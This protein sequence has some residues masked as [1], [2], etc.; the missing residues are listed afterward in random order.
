LALTH[1]CKHPR[2]GLRRRA[3]VGSA[4]ILALTHVCKHPRLGLRRRAPVGSADILAL[5]HVCKH[6]RLGL[7]R[8][9]MKTVPAILSA[10]GFVPKAKKGLPA[11]K[12]LAAHAKVVVMKVRG[13]PR[14]T[15]GC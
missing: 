2:L 6:P 10:N 14:S 13:L 11:M 1:V 4:D 8:R 7:R 12:R 3:P 5:T 15:P 9:Q